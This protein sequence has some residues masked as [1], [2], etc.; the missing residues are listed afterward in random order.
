MDNYLDVFAVY[1]TPVQL[2]MLLFMIA[3]IP[4]CELPL[5]VVCFG[6]IRIVRVLITR[7]ASSIFAKLRR[8]SWELFAFLEASTL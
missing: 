2:Y 5:P 8:C 1:D 4:N 3:L 7:I 6:T